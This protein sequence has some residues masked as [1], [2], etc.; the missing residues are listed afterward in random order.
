[1][2]YGA[3]FVLAAGIGGHL[4]P[5]GL[6]LL[7]SPM[8]SQGR[9]ALPNMLIQP[10]ASSL[11]TALMC[12]VDPASADMSAIERRVSTRVGLDFRTKTTQTSGDHWTLGKR[13][14]PKTDIS[15]DTRGH[16]PPSSRPGSKRSSAISKRR[17]AARS[18]R[19]RHRH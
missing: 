11:R 8:T 1:M 9:P 6:Y 13:P 17:V 3:C 14:C 12:P 4:N 10:R 18:S 5:F 19:N 7:R 16:Q 15:L 2:E